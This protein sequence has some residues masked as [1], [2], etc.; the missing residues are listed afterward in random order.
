[1]QLKHFFMGRDSTVLLLDDRTGGDP[2]VQSLAHGVISLE[3]LPQGYGAERRR[4]RIAKLRGVS[5]R[6]GFH[7]YKIQTGGLVVY[8]R[9]VAAEHEVEAQRPTLA[10]GVTGLDKLLG[11]GLDPGTSTLIVG[12]AGTGKSTLMAHYASAAARHGIKCAL[13]LFDE[14]K[15]TLFKRAAAL[16]IGLEEHI[17]SGKISVRQVDP[18]EL[19]PDELA[20]EMRRDVEENGCGFIALDSLNGYL[21]AMPDERFLTLQLHEMLQY[22]AHKRIVTVMVMAQQGAL[23]T[24]PISPIDISYVADSIVL[25]RFFEAMGKVR[26]AIS[27]LK[28]RSGVHEATI[29]ELRVENGGVNVGEP[30][31][32]FQGVLSGAPEFVGD[33]TK[34]AR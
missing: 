21:H 26:K 9:L 33:R 8:P 4:L 13:Y 31:V 32:E 27:V 18:A 7:D 24:E 19:A 34:L 11:G 25:L 29:R 14:G 12:S 23:A 3:Q 15:E 17:K 28:K 6:G 30:L 20:Q 22:L 10:S 1:M 16:G 5:F 2:Q